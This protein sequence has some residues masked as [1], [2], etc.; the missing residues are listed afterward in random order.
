M[1]NGDTAR[2]PGK[3]LDHSIITIQ[4][5]KQPFLRVFQLW[6]HFDGNLIMEWSL[7]MPYY[8]RTFISEQ[9]RENRMSGKILVQFL[10]FLACDAYKPY[11]YFE[12]SIQC[13]VNFSGLVSWMDFILHILILLNEL[14]DLAIISLML[15]YSKNQENAFLNDPKSQKRGFWPF[16]WVWSVGSTWYCIL[17]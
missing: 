15:D 6:A 1:G 5:Q 2:F 10:R 13:W 16:S 8:D 4:C 3:N 11:S 7:F 17:W 12:W 14:N 9:P